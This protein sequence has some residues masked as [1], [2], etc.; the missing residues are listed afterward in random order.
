MTICMNESEEYF[1]Y[2]LQKYRNLCHDK[3]IIHQHTLQN[4]FMPPLRKL[5]NGVMRNKWD[6][7]IVNGK[8][9]K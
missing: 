9:L 3:G 2:V 7:I 4:I 6:L 1:L 8:R 5:L